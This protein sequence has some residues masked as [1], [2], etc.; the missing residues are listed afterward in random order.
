M[1]YDELYKHIHNYLNPPTENIEL[2]NILC[3]WSGVNKYDNFYGC[4]I[5]DM[6]KYNMKHNKCLDS[7]SLGDLHLFIQQSEISHDDSSPM[8]C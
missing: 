6:I 3:K 5:D 7:T 2:Y 4:D 1:T 8:E